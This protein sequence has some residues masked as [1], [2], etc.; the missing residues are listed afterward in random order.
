VPSR[1]LDV[2]SLSPGQVAIE[3][4]S[5][6]PAASAA[7]H[8]P[9]RLADNHQEVAADFSAD[10]V[11]NPPRLGQLGTPELRNEIIIG[12]DD[13]LVRAYRWGRNPG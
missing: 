12:R 7:L 6:S 13:V 2:P 11:P 5:N 9:K 3:K 10:R 8:I 4:Q 1:D